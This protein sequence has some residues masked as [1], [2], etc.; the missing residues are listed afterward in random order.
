M[1]CIHDSLNVSNSAGLFIRERKSSK[2][3]TTRTVRC[4]N[5]GGKKKTLKILIAGGGIGGLVFALAAKRSGFDVKVFEKDLTAVRGEGLERGPIQLLSSA[6]GLMESIDKDAAR[7]IM[8]SGYVTGDRL[9]GLADGT[10]G[11]WYIYIY[12]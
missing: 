11:Q 2:R 5:T 1:A 9:N 10:T 12:N 7:E 8:E 3:L 4:E 6:M